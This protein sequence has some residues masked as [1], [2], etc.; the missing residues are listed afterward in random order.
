MPLEN[1]TWELTVTLPSDG[2]TRAPQIWMDT[3]GTF[4][5]NVRVL[6]KEGRLFAELNSSK[7][8]V[9]RAELVSSEQSVTYRVI[10]EHKIDGQWE[11]SAIQVGSNGANNSRLPAG[12]LNPRSNLLVISSEDVVEHP[13][14]G[15]YDWN[16]CIFYIAY[17]GF[18]G[19]AKVEI[20]RSDVGV[21]RQNRRPRR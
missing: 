19:N 7:K 21:E 5:Q 13:V 11:E 4:E 2:R 15:G 12:E 16:D 8:G 3:K 10:I 20:A 1:P 14:D 18:L 9:R 17:N 6:D